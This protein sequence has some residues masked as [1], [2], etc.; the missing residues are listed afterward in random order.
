MT[1]FDGESTNKVANP[2]H[3]NRIKRNLRRKQQQ[4]SR[5]QKGSNKRAKAR[6]KVASVYEYLTKDRADFY[7]K[8]SRKL[9]DD[10]QVLVF[11]N[12]NIKGLK[13]TSRSNSR[14]RGSANG[15][16]PATAAI[17]V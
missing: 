14:R 2:R 10:N 15:E 7:H 4:L 13:R 5:K 11:E 3:F 12:L 6:K 9:V 1:V 17:A 16:S 8:L